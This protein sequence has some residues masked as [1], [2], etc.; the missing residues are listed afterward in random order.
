MVLMIMLVKVHPVL[1]ELGLILGLVVQVL[2]LVLGALVPTLVL[3]VLVPTLV[4]EEQD[5]TQVL[6]EQDPTSVLE[7]LVPTI[8]THIQLEM[9]ILLLRMSIL[10]TMWTQHR[11]ILTKLW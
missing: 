10:Q 9:E 2:T 11:I 8:K 1:A 5:Q 3:E 7:A 6:E 4:L